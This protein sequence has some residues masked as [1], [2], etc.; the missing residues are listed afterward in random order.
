MSEHR[1]EIEK[2]DDHVLWAERHGPVIRFHRTAKSDTGE[3][4][5][6]VVTELHR[7]TLRNVLVWSDQGESVTVSLKGPM[8]LQIQQHARELGLTEE[9]FVWHAVKVFIEVGTGEL[10]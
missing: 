10:H 7:E 8:A 2:G 4:E 3:G 5:D 1:F 6:T 9:L